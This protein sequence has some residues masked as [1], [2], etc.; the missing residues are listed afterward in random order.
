MYRSGLRVFTLDFERAGARD[1]LGQNAGVR[2]YF[3][4]LV[5]KSATK[6]G[7]LIGG[8][9]SSVSDPQTKWRLGKAS[10]SIHS[11]LG[12]AIVPDP[13]VSEDIECWY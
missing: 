3:S 2:H 11:C 12:N 8:E 9:V 7:C 4:F 5:P 6:F 1:F 10:Q 13:Q